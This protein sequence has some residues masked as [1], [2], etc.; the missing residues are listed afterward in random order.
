MDIL[1][2]EMKNHLIKVIIPFWEKL[3]DEDY[4]GFMDIWILTKA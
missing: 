2:K 4:G 1:K 3:C